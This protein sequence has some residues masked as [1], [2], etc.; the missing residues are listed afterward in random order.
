MTSLGAPLVFFA[1]LGMLAGLAAWGWHVG[2]G[3]MRIVLA[4]GAPLVVAIV[5]GAFLAPRARKPLRPHVLAI[6]VRLDLLLLGAAAAWGASI[7]WLAVV[8]AAAAVVGTAL[9]WLDN[10]E[11]PVPGSNTTT[12]S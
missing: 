10:P 7:T 9:A 4:V 12:T 6:L 5:W 2:D 1:E 11:A 3:P 8:T